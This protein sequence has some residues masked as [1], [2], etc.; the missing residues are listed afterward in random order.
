MTEKPPWSAHLDYERSHSG[1][2]V[3]TALARGSR[4]TKTLLDMRTVE[5]NQRSQKDFQQTFL[6]F[7]N[8]HLLVFGVAGGMLESAT[9]CSTFLMSKM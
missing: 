2:R 6:A 5:Q 9:F 7:F 8:T 3:A 1:L 4:K